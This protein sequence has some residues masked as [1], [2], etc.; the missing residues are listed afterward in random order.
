VL[1]AGG[2][3]NPTTAEIA[4]ERLELGLSGAPWTR[5]IEWLWRALHGDLG[6][7]W[8]T[9][10]PVTQ[11]LGE[12]LPATIRLA[13]SALVIAIA[14][15]LVLGI[16]GALASGRLGDWLSR[17]FSLLMISTPSFVIGVL[18]L[19][20]VVI[21]FGFGHVLTDGTWGTV[22]LPAVCLALAPAAIWSRI[23]R[24]SLLEA[25]GAAYLH[26][27]AAR[28]ASRSRQLVVHALPNALVPFLTVVGIG[29]AGLLAGA[30]VI[31]V[32]FTWPGVG[33]YTVQAI[34]AG[35]VPVVQG[36][37]LLAVFAYVAVSLIVDIVVRLIDPR[38]QSGTVANTRRRRMVELDLEAAAESADRI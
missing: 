33:R 31:E 25:R 2:I 28:G 6:Q 21:R 23:L 3:S 8:L 1:I 35:D 29:T 5:Y 24:A 13:V 18:L 11:E 10:R 20:V 36:Y 34:Q 30:P 16:V 26:L 32:V 27:S 22:L 12:R 19:D 9:G 17:M 7:S 15:S 4:Q 37:T 38:R 14:L